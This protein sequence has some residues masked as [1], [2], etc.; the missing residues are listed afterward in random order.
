MDGEQLYDLKEVRLVA[1]EIDSLEIKISASSADAAKK[2]RSLAAAVKSLNKEFNQGKEAKGFIKTLEELGS[3]LSGLGGTA[4]NLKDIAQSARELSKVNL[5]RAVN[6]IRSMGSAMKEASSAAAKLSSEMQKVNSVSGARALGSGNGVAGL[7]GGSGTNALTGGK[8]AMVVNDWTEVINGEGLRPFHGLDPEVENYIDAEWEEIVDY[9][10]KLTGGN[11]IAGLLT[12]GTGGKLTNTAKQATGG[13]QAAGAPFTFDFGKGSGLGGRLGTMFAGLGKEAAAF[14]NG[15][16]GELEKEIP[17]A[18]KFGEVCTAASAGPEALAAEVGKLTAEFVIDAFRTSIKWASELGK[19]ALSAGKAMG[20]YLWDKSPI[21]RFTGAVKTLTRKWKELTSG[22]ARIAV[23]RALRTAIKKVTENVNEGIEALYNYQQAMGGG[24]FTEVMDSFTRGVKNVAGSLGALAA[25]VLSLLQPAI[26]GALNLIDRLATALASLFATL[27][28]NIWVKTT[29]SA[30]TFAD[31]MKKGAGSAK[32]WKN[33]L[34]GFDEINRLEDNNGGGGGGIGYEEGIAPLWAEDLKKLLDEKNFFGF[35]RKV[36]DLLDET[37]NRWDAYDWGTKLGQKIENGM[38]IAVG[39]LSHP[40]LFQDAGAQLGKALRGM[41]ER[42]NPEVLGSAMAEATNSVWRVL[43]GFLDEMSRYDFGGQLSRTMNAW[44]RKIDFSVMVRDL[45]KG[46]DMVLQTISR[47]ISNFDLSGAVDKLAENLGTLFGNMGELIEKYHPGEAILEWVLTVDWAGAVERMAP[48]INKLLESM[49]DG[50]KKINEHW[51]EI[52]KAFEDAFNAIDWQS[53]VDIIIEG[54]KLAAKMKMEAIRTFAREFLIDALPLPETMKKIMRETE[55]EAET[56][57][58][59]LTDE[60]RTAWD[61][62]KSVIS[63]ATGASK[64]T[65]IADFFAIRKKAKEETDGLSSDVSA[66]TGTLGQTL[67]SKWEEIKNN[68][69]ANTVAVRDNSDKDMKKMKMQIETEMKAAQKSASNAMNTMKN[70]IT[71]GSNNA[72]NNLSNAMNS[73]R[74]AASSMASGV[75]SSSSSAYSALSNLQSR[76]SSV[77][78]NV[79]SWVNNAASS[80]LGLS[81]RRYASGGFPETGEVFI[82]RESGPELVGKMGGSSAVA[83]NG[84][85]IEGI[86]QGVYEAMS[87]VMSGYGGEQTVEIRLDSRVLAE[88][89]TKRQRQMARANG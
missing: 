48:G 13:N 58:N 87:S 49:V 89:V 28:G 54:A 20:K 63:F 17:L 79:I 22:L 2:V 60:T 1:T 81:T 76:A 75:Q 46:M 26:L 29:A 32:E 55:G 19:A 74:S 10:R 12:E 71:N 66:V 43:E 53:V 35:G 61:K 59:V 41:A 4:E 50:L 72:K 85:I 77:V 6:N 44:F 34:L 56:G 88:A 8:G 78:S 57:Y 16:G 65:A 7:P 67:K 80:L 83:N 31:T 52:Q 5:S 3:A 70:D 37:I 45:T 42:I 51:P 64:A 33:Q 14:A 47:F 69:S 9:T 11:G 25:N 15:F 62:I 18:R 82:A 38:E 68:V 36:A 40:A 21:G 84:Q 30:E 73:I 27:G 23:Y 86:K 24:R 39:F